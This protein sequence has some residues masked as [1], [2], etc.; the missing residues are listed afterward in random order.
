MTIS[1][2]ERAR[3]LVDSAMA[4][5]SSVGFGNEQLEAAIATAIRHACNE[6]LEEAAAILDEYRTDDDSDYSAGQDVAAKEA[7]AEIR[8]LKDPTP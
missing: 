2:E 7:A 5:D 6:K 3:A 4:I 1:P 8:S